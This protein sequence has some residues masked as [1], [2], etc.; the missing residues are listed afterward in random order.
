MVEQNVTIAIIVVVL[1]VFF[2]AVAF[3]VYFLVHRAAKHRGE[4]VVEL[5]E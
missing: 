3:S 2:A 1:L 4:R 5:E